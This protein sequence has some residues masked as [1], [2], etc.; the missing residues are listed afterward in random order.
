M[1][2][3]TPASLPDHAE[4]EAKAEGGEE[5]NDAEQD[6]VI[7]ATPPLEE[8]QEKQG[9]KPVAASGLLSLAMGSG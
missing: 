2:A 4:A 5:E 1:S 6:E 8:Q 7:A 9:N 3:G